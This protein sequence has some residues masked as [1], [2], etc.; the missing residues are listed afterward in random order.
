MAKQPLVRKAAISLAKIWAIHLPKYVRK[1][2]CVTQ[3]FA[4]LLDI[5]V[6]IYFNYETKMI[7]GQDI[8]E[9]QTGWL[10][11]V[12]FTSK[13]IDAR[14]KSFK[15]IPILNAGS[16][17]DLLYGLAI[18]S[19]KIHSQNRVVVIGGEFGSRIINE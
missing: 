13:L 9:L 10:L 18:Q 3:H 14:D 19:D 15:V 5:A 17:G 2:R 12:Q 7:R 8:W 1:H 16:L 11:W 6:R 4:L